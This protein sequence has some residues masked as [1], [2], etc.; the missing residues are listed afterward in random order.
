M[1]GAGMTQKERVLKSLKAAGARGITQVDWTG[2]SGTPDGGPP[3]TR[4]A[5]RILDLSQDGH[6]IVKGSIRDKCRVYKLEPSQPLNA[7]IIPI[8][9]LHDERHIPSPYEYEAAA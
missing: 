3:I 7:P 5:A 4:V 1:R 2:S 9:L 8:T 6:T